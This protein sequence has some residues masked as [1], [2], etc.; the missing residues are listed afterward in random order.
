[1]GIRSKLIISGLGLLAMRKWHKY[2]GFL[3]GVC[4]WL[5]FIAVCAVL[6]G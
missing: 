6:P 1:M 3:N 4:Y 5:M 2:K